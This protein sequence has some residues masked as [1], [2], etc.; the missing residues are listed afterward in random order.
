VQAA[1]REAGISMR[2]VKKAKQEL[3]VQSVA[4]REEGKR[5]IQR[6]SWSLPGA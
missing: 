1:A 5:G 2:T 6:W 3:D 4:E